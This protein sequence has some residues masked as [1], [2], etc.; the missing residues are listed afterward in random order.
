MSLKSMFSQE[1]ICALIL[2]VMVAFV[3]LSSVA[4]PTAEAGGLLK[5]AAAAAIIRGGP[6]IPIPIRY[7]VKHEKKVTL[8]DHHHHD[9]HH[10]HHERFGHFGGFSF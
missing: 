5:L 7:P 8:L 2:S 9:D 4:P 1:K 3:A 10:H 6:I